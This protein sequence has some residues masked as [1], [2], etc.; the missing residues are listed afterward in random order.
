MSENF[1]ALIPCPCVE[2]LPAQSQSSTLGHLLLIIRLSN[3]NHRCILSY[4]LGRFTLLIILWDVLPDPHTFRKPLLCFA[5][6]NKQHL[7][8]RILLTPEQSW[9]FWSFLLPVLVRV[10]LSKNV[11]D[12]YTSVR[13]W[14]E[15]ILDSWWNR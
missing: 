10:F 2:C 11:K 9:I 12:Y 5:F 4:L 14:S 1:L 8:F 13:C 6:S 3:G 7:F 15:S